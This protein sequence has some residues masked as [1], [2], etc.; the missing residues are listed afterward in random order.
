MASLAHRLSSYARLM[1][2]GEMLE[3]MALVDDLN[4]AAEELVGDCDHRETWQHPGP[5]RLWTHQV[6]GRALAN[7]DRGIMNRAEHL[8][9]NGEKRILWRFVNI[10]IAVCATGALLLG[11]LNAWAIKDYLDFK[12]SYARELAERAR[13]D[14]QR[15]ERQKWQEAALA[16]IAA[17]LDITIP[18]PPPR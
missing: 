9:E 16:A 13:G 14:A 15:D 4:E 1:D 17:K 3:A 11:A 6:P 7:I 12:Q 8:N 5:D 2:A 18:P 10:L